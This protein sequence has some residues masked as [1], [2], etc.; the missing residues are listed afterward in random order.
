MAEAEKLSESTGGG[1]D[2]VPSF[3]K[4]KRKCVPRRRHR[5]TTEDPFRPISEAQGPRVAPAPPTR[6]VGTLDLWWRSLW[7]PTLSGMLPRG[8]TLGCA[9]HRQLCTR[10]LTPPPRPQVH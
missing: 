1:I 6:R 5:A 2:H 10:R 8:A 3:D 7:A 4:S 9:I